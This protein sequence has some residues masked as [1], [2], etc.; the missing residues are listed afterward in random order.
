MK[1]LIIDNDVRDIERRDID[2]YEYYHKDIAKLFVDCPDDTEIGYHY[3]NG[4]F[5]NP[6]PPN[7]VV[8]ETEGDKGVN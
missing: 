8:T 5:I 3:I 7:E 4:E 6:N 1:A 2:V